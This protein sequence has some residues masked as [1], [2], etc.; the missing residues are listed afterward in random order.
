MTREELKAHC[1]KQIKACEVWARYIGVEPHGKVYEEHKLI[2]ELLEQE[3]TQNLIID[4]N[5]CHTS[6]QLDSIATTKN[7]LGVDCISKQAVLV[8]MRNNHRDGGRDIDG[9]YIEG[10]YSEKLYDAITS[11]P[12]A[13]PQ[14]PR[15]KECKW[16]KDS[17]GKY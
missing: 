2:L 14:E 13:T 9:D 7:D 1:L 11:L 16:W 5:N 17:D 8:A 6:E 10:N 12:P 4:W 3:P 15:C